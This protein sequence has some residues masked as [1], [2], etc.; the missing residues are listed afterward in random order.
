MKLLTTSF[1]APIQTVEAMAKSLTEA[2]QWLNSTTQFSTWNLIRKYITS[3]DFHPTAD[4]TEKTKELEK[5]VNEADS[6]LTQTLDKMKNLK[7]LKIDDPDE[8]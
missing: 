3:E 4:T 5:I 6:T 1:E 7:E 8:K 2:Q